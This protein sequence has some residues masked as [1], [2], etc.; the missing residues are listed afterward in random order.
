M[1][2]E[3][4][5]TVSQKIYIFIQNK[6]YNKKIYIIIMYIFFEKLYIIKIYCSIIAVAHLTIIIIIKLYY[7]NN[8][9]YYYYYYYYGRVFI[10]KIYIYI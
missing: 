5:Y 9:N 2:F 1:S 6:I 8:N 4:Y 3:Y 10:K 7:N